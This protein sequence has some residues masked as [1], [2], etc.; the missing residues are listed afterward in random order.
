MGFLLLGAARP[1]LSPSYS[2]SLV[3]LPVL[4][5]WNHLCF[6]VQPVIK[7]VVR[8]LLPSQNVFFSSA[9]NLNSQL[10]SGLI[11]L[12]CSLTLSQGLILVIIIMILHPIQIILPLLPTKDLLHIFRR[13]NNWWCLASHQCSHQPSKCPD[14]WNQNL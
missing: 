1:S 7:C 5:Q 12:H 6:A 3:S 11:A 9:S 10:P 8:P 4:P 2:S 14:G 13:A